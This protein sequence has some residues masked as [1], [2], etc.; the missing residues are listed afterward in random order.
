M[1]ILKDT[2]KD[3]E[4]SLSREKEFNAGDHRINADYLVNVLRNFLM[5]TDPNE[6]SKLVSVICQILQFRPDEMRIINQKWALK[7]GSGSGLA[8][9][10]RG[11]SSVAVNINNHHHSSSSSSSNSSGGKNAGGTV[12]AS[13]NASTGL[14]VNMF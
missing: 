12:D 7:G 4:L 13:Y 2:I 3:L 6:R 11:N 5:A 1:S 10:F 9:W 8:G 14:D